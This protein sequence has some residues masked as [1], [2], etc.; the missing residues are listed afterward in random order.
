VNVG[1][2]QGFVRFGTT[3]HR[4]LVLL[5]ELGDLGH[6][7]LVEETGAD[8]RLVAVTLQRLA[9]FKFIFPAG[10]DAQPATG[11]KT[12]RRWAL[13]RNPNLRSYRPLTVA[14]RQARYR[15]TTR[16]RVASVWEFR[17]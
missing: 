15:A 10:V 12:Q 8:P 4:V 7:E 3:P 6:R 9:R 5:H 14:E 16:R 2:A 13:K 17:P 11:E 1:L